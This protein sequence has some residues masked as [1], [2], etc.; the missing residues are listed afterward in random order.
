MPSIGFPPS[1]EV[2]STNQHAGEIVRHS[3]PLSLPKPLV[4]SAPLLATSSF[5][6]SATLLVMPCRYVSIV[7][8]PIAPSSHAVLPKG[9]GGIRV[10]ICGSLAGALTRHEERSRAQDSPLVHYRLGPNTTALHRPERAD[11]APPEW[12]PKPIPIPWPLPQS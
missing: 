11:Q 6:A 4:P 2:E 7:R 5:K 3:L 1:K 8:V 10:V 12:G 9:C